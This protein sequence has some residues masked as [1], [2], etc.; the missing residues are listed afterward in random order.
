MRKAIPP[1][2]EPPPEPD[3]P[4]VVLWL[5]DNTRETRG[6]VATARATAKISKAVRF[7]L[8]SSAVRLAL[9]FVQSGNGWTSANVPN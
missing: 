3:E 7:M 6:A 2:L 1:D 8:S 4:D 5:P 9:V